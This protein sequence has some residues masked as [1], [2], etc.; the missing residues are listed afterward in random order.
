MQREEKIIGVVGGMGPDA[1]VD[2]FQTI[3]NKTPAAEDQDHYRILI[4]NNPK[5]PDRTEAILADGKNPLKELIKTAKV[6]EKAGASFLVMPCNTAH[7]FVE[8]MQNKLEIEIINM[9]KE[10][11]VEIN[12]DDKIKKAAI[13]GTKGIIET[14]I[15]NK[16]LEKLGIEVLKPDQAEKNKLM[17]IIYAIKSAKQTAE[18]QQELSK[19]A[20]SLINR[21]AEAVILGCTELPLL[22]DKDNFNYPLF[23]PQEILAERA[24]TKMKSFI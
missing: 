11:A 23:I 19:I 9:I 21:G 16:E 10:V 8:E 12:K 22:F 3:I 14:G 18:M 24:I 17:E 13:M 2:L 1:T 20:L 7:Y 15:Y 6:L 5:I 4:Y